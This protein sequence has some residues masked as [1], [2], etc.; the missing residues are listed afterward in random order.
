MSP[1]SKLVVMAAPEAMMSDANW[2][3]VCIGRSR[4]DIDT[5]VEL[6]FAKPE[7]PE[8]PEAPVDAYSVRSFLMDAETFAML[9]QPFVAPAFWPDADVT[10]ANRAR[11]AMVYTGEAADDVIAS[12]V[13]VPVP[14]ALD[15]FV[16]EP[17]SAPTEPSEPVEQE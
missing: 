12:R 11:T 7:N 17:Y 13:D 4:A 3:A 2:M 8:D 1:G 10:A 16:L 6:N 15:E 9:S 5:F 14:Q